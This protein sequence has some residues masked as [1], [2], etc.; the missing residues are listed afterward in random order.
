[1]SVQTEINRIKENV[2]DSFA[3]IKE[4]G[5]EVSVAEKSDTLPTAIGAAFDDVNALLDTINGVIV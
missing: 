4:Y 3:T 2:S 1:M 5:M